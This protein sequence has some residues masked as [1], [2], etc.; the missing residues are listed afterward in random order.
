MSLIWSSCT[1]QLS[2]RGFATLPPWSTGDAGLLSLLVPI[3]VSIRCTCRRHD[4]VEFHTGAYASCGCE[5]LSLS[6]RRMRVSSYDTSKQIFP[7]WLGHLCS[8]GS[9]QPQEHS[10]TPTTLE[11]FRFNLFHQL[12]RVGCQ[13]D[14]AQ[15]R[16]VT[17]NTNSAYLFTSLMLCIYEYNAPPKHK[18]KNHAKVY[19]VDGRDDQFLG[20]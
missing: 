3:S 9:Q 20:T 14:L 13:G 7:V 17:S 8:L 2:P 12:I 16:S 18:T 1:V 19:K 5:Q 4:P 6:S 15:I 11:T 10:Y